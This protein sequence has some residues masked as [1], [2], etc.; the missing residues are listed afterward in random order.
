MSAAPAPRKRGFDDAFED[1]TYVREEGEATSHELFE[2]YYR[3]QNILPDHEWPKMM[4]ALKRPLPVTFRL[5]KSAA[6]AAIVNECLS[7]ADEQGLLAP[8]SESLTP[9][10]HDNR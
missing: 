10:E 4:M 6:S 3:A 7:V 5:C 8:T 1:D 9:L 2:M